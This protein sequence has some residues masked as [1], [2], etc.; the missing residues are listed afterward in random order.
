MKQIPKSLIS[1]R[2]NEQTKNYFNNNLFDEENC[3]FPRRI[4]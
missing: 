2:Y 1:M 4:N 3:Q